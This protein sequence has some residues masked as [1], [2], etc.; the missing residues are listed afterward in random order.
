MKSTNERLYDLSI[1]MAKLTKSLEYTQDQLDH[2][3]NTIKTD[4][5]NLD[6]AVKEFEKKN[7]IIP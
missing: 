2:E 1:E 3:L 6:S 4:T 5:K 7:W